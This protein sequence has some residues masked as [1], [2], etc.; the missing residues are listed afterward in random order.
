ML[1]WAAQN[2]RI[3]LTHDKATM[4]DFAYERLAA[5]NE[6]PG[7]LVVKSRF[8]VGQAIEEVLLVS[9]CSQQEEWNQR[10]VSAV[11]I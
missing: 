3:L 9:M 6:M 8:P 11:M 1:E 2:N 4:P 5:G 7:V 10:V